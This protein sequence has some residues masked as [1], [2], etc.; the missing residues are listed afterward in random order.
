MTL[1][2]LT[3]FTL[4]FLLQKGRFKSTKDFNRVLHC[5]KLKD[6]HTSCYYA[7][8]LYTKFMSQKSLI[9]CNNCN[10]L[11]CWHL[12]SQNQ[13]LNLCQLA[14]IVWLSGNNYQI[15]FPSIHLNSLVEIQWI[16]SDCFNMIMHVLSPGSENHL[17][18]TVYMLYKQQFFVSCFTDIFLFECNERDWKI[19][20]V[21]E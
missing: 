14:Q 12:A 11:T 2:W 10:K 21:G 13:L 15:W 16:N 19:V 3:W 1:N 17:T 4:T 6:I 18:T 7:S 5:L 20:N 9:C 8:F